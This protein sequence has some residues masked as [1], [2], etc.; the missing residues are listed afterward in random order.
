MQDCFVLVCNILAALTLT[1]LRS[2]E[3][4]KKDRNSEMFFSETG[5]LFVY[6]FSEGFRQPSNSAHCINAGPAK[7]VKRCKRRLEKN[8]QDVPVLDPRGPP[9]DKTSDP[10]TRRLAVPVP[11]VLDGLVKQR[12]AVHVS[13]V[14]CTGE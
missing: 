2:L 14:L 7:V 3:T 8:L 10:Q 12:E 13:L 11:L 5:T 9:V 4:W 1:D 6:S